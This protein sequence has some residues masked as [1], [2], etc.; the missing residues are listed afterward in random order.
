[1]IINNIITLIKIMKIHNLINNKIIYLKSPLINYIIIIIIIM[2]LIIICTIII[3]KIKVEL[4]KNKI[5]TIKIKI[6]NK[7][8]CK[9]H[10]IRIHQINI[11]IK[12]IWGILDI[13]DNININ[14]SELNLFFIY[15]L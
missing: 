8:L 11:N 7:I 1:M 9:D 12:I 2:K 3:I 4:I 6:T 15:F 5:I 14:K 10:M 13:K